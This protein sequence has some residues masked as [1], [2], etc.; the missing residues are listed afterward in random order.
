MPSHDGDCDTDDHPGPHR[1]GILR[2]TAAA[3]R[4]AILQAVSDGKRTSG[5][6]AGSLFSRKVIGADN[7]SL[8][9]PYLESLCR[10]GILEKVKL[11]GKS[12]Y[13]YEHTSPVIDLYY[14]L[15]Q[16]YGFGDR[17]LPDRQVK[18]VLSEK[19]PY[20]VE[21]FFAS[22]LSK[23]LGLGK[24]RIIERDHEVDIVLTDFQRLAFVGEVKWSSHITEGDI[25]RAEDVLGSYGCKRALIVPDKHALPREPHGVEVWD[26]EALLKMESPAGAQQSS[27]ESKQRI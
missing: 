17:D 3:L 26:M 25:R 18:Q 13:A 4:Q 20:H 6:M 19:T 7:P 8:V 10:L 14:Y 27:K 22:M 11:F 24:E 1:R 5:E 2:G 23:T 21:R 9:H 15:Q 16:K 12:R